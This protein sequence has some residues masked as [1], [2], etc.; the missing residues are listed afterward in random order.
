MKFRYNG[1]RAGLLVAALA[2]VLGA[3][4]PLQAA[5]GE[6]RIDPATPACPDAGPSP[7]LACDKELLLSIRDTLTGDR[8]EKFPT[9][10][11]DAPLTDFTGVEV[12]GDPRRVI[13]LRVDAVWDADE[14]ALGGVVPPALSRLPWL[15][16]LSIVGR[17]EAPEHQ[18]G[19]TLPPELGQLS[20]LRELVLRNHR[21]TGPI[22]P[23]L[24]QLRNLQ[25]L[26]LMNNQLTGPI[27][28]ELQH[29]TWMARLDLSHNRLTGPVP[30]ELGQPR[31]LRELD[32]SHNRLTGPVPTELGRLRNLRELDLSHNRLT[33][34]VPTELGHGL[35]M[36]A[37]TG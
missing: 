26:D 29:L 12:D 23:E 18:L 21:L 7:S 36:L 28:T 20:R 35:A 6:P 27:P 5:G 10:Q 17:P 15:Q 30:T 37:T 33:G 3:G 2:L 24:G 11:P 1:L 9:W 16:E 25:D 32:L 22:P 14:P 13:G 19:G 34:P 4:R 31:N 8:P